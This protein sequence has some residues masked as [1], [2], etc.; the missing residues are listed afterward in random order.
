[1]SE[2]LYTFILVRV[3]RRSEPYWAGAG[4][5]YPLLSARVLPS[6]SPPIENFSKS[7]TC[8]LG[9]LSLQNILSDLLSGLIL[10]SVSRILPSINTLARMP[11]HLAV[12][13]YTTHLVHGT[14]GKAPCEKSLNFWSH[15]VHGILKDTLVLSFWEFFTFRNVHIIEKDSGS[16]PAP[17]FLSFYILFSSVLER[18]LQAFCTL[19]LPTYPMTP[20]GQALSLPERPKKL[21]AR[22][23]CRSV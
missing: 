3:S 13:F 12:D 19:A 10:L 22:S 6:L 20:I 11:R 15:S 23:L 21:C 8:N 5:L 14:W 2:S 16:I 18:S 4:L 7:K 1:M 9:R 17:A